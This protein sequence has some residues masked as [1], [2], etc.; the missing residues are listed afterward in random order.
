MTM[1]LYQNHW[2]VHFDW[3]NYISIKLLKYIYIYILTNRESIR[4]FYT[5]P[6]EYYTTFLWGKFLCFGMGRCPEY[7][8]RKKKFI[9]KLLKMHLHICTCLQFYF[10]GITP[11]VLLFELPVS[12]CVLGVGIWRHTSLFLTASWFDFIIVYSFS[13]GWVFRAFRTFRYFQKC[14]DRYSR[15]STWA[16]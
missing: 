11:Y 10:M 2:I 5:Q 16:Q 13:Y 7:V 4:F 9:S 15:T 1:V 14:C 6:M 8:V 12:L 3:V